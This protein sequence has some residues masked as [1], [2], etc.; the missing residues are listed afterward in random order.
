[1]FILYNKAANK[2][3]MWFITNGINGGISAMV[4]EAFYEERISRAT[5]TIDKTKINL[6]YLDSND[7]DQKE[8]NLIGIVDAKTLQNSSLFDGQV[9]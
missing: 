1:M 5:T 7:L 8:L 9:R 4:G 6:S 3:E 2:T